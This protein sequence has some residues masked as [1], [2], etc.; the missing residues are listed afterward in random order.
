[1]GEAHTDDEILECGGTMAS[2]SMTYTLDIQDNILL[3]R[4]AL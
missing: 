2:F 1:V 4:A 3:E